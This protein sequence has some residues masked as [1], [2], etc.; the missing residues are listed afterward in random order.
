MRIAFVRHGERRKNETDPE[1]TSFGFRMVEE[2]SQ[3]LSDFG[4]I[5][6]LALSTPTIRTQ[7][8]ATT[9][10]GRFPHVSIERIEH[11]PET[12][13]E[14]ERWTQSLKNHHSA[15]NNVLLV[16]HHPTME[17]LIQCY[18]PAPVVVS[19]HQFAVGLI[20]QTAPETSWVLTHAWP[21]RTS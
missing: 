13:A 18:G 19:R 21:G 9:L 20:L 10:L 6:D 7:Q 3:W 1:L 17:M 14:W 15:P 11:A 2:T 16:G 12:Q 8:T 5:P 4:F